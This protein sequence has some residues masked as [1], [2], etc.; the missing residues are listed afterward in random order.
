MFIYYLFVWFFVFYALARI[1]KQL[2]SVETDMIWKI[3]I[4]RIGALNINWKWDKVYSCGFNL[5]EKKCNVKCCTHCE[6]TVHM[7]TSYICRNDFLNEI[8]YNCCTVYLVHYKFSASADNP[9]KGGERE[10]EHCQHY[11][12]TCFSLSQ[13]IWVVYCYLCLRSPLQSTLNIQPSFDYEPF[14]WVFV[15]YT[16]VWN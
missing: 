3:Y 1:I 10:R 6:N 14:L 15:V 11:K 7:K 9:K 16:H 5:R 8:H 2:D 4:H 13:Y 12:M